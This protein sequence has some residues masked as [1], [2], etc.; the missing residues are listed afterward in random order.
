MNLPD[1][2]NFK[3]FEWDRGN[4]FKSFIKHKVSC[5]EAEEVFFDK[6]IKMFCDKE[7]SQK[8][9]RFLLLGKTYKK[10]KLTVIFTMRENNIRIISA[11]DMHKKERITYEKK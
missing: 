6:E 4:Q 1:F 8:E 2:S 7:H 3:D 5:Q 9:D 10:R 11:R